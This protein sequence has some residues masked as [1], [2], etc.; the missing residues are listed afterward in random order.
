[1][2]FI[3]TGTGI[4]I[5]PSPSLHLNQSKQLLALKLNT[6]KQQAQKGSLQRLRLLNLRRGYVA[7]AGSLAIPGIVLGV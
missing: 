3:H 6:V 4:D 7:N 5:Q 2:I 1:V